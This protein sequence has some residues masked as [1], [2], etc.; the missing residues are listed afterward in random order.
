MQRKAALSVT[1]KWNAP[2]KVDIK[3]I[4]E[5][6]GCNPLDKIIRKYDKMH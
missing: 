6:V 4:T 5:E 3:K 2:P 1:G